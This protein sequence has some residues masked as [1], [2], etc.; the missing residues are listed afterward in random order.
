MG[1]FILH[2]KI[3]PKLVCLLI[4]P[5]LVC[6]LRMKGFFG[7][8]LRDL[9][10]IAILRGVI[11]NRETLLLWKSQIVITDSTARI[12]HRPECMADGLGAVAARSIPRLESAHRPPTRMSPERRES[13][14][15]NGVEYLA[16]PVILAG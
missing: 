10:T 3:N 4:N 14:P 5:K 7:G 1:G 16:R 8:P 11:K 9:W 13:W 2:Q 15:T 6:L 12:N